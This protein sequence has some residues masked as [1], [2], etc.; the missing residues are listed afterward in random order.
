M[1][2]ST[3]PTGSTEPSSRPGLRELARAANV[4]ATVLGRIAGSRIQLG[5]VDLDLEEAR[6]AYDGGLER[7]LAG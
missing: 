3:G 6:A 1:T 2:E 4:P 7:A 5:P